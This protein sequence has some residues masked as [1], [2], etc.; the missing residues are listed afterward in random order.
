MIVWFYSFI[1]QDKKTSKFVE[2]GT[3]GGLFF[4]HATYL[5][6]GKRSEAACFCLYRACLIPRSSR[7]RA[8]SKS[9][10]IVPLISKVGVVSL[11]WGWSLCDPSS[12]SGLVDL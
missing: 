9:T 5:H 7:S 1:E 8:W 12:T 6:F 2:K 4:R 10:M 3:E 11:S